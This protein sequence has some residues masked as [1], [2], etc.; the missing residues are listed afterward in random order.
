MAAIALSGRAQRLLALPAA[1]STH[2]AEASSSLPDRVLTAATDALDRGETHYTDRP[3][4]L[5]LREKV[6]ERLGQRYDLTVDPKTSVLITCG[7]TEAR[8]VALQQLLAAGDTLLCLGDTALVEAAVI[9]RGAKL[10]DARAE[11]SAKELEAVTG[12]YLSASAAPGSR[13]EYLAQA[14]AQG[15]WLIFDVT[16]DADAGFHPASDPALAAHTVTVGGIG[17]DAGFSGWR[18]GF[19]AA[20]DKEAPALRSFKQ[21]LTIC[22]TNV[23]QWAALALL[24]GAA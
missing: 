20:P 2:Q 13:S 5:P 18:V 4:I 19:L 11:P 24:G 17:T 23:S 12:L 1:K 22:T 15:W 21:S 10:I 8:F 14:K 3:G 7:D 6:A 16:G 9:I